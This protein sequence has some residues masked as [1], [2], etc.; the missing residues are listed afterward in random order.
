MS[1]FEQ[2][3]DT[4]PLSQLR[5][6][7]KIY[8]LGIAGTGM[9]TVAGLCKEAGF[10]VSGSDQAVY[11]PTAG[12][13]AAAGIP[14]YTP[15]HSDNLLKAK[16][17]LMVVGNA[18]SRGH[19]EL[20]YWISQGRP[21][22]SY[23]QVLGECFL[24]D[25]ASVVMTG[26]HG[27]TTTTALMAHVL[28]ELGEDP[29]W[30]IGGVP[31]NQEQSFRLGKSPLF[32][33]EGDEYNTAFFDKGAK[34]LHYRSRVL[35]LNN[36]EHDHVDIYPDFASVLAMFARLLTSC[37]ERGLIVANMDS[38]GVRQLLEANNAQHK[39]LGFAAGD[40]PQERRIIYG[41]SSYDATR[42][43]WVGT[44][45]TEQWGRLEVATQLPGQHN[46]SN[47]AGMLGCLARLKEGGHIKGSWGARELLASIASFPGVQK[48]FEE[49][50]AYNGC[51]V[52]LDF[53]HHPTAVG[54]VLEIFA[55]RYPAR[56]LIVAFD[57]KNVSS[58]RNIFFPLY[59]TAFRRAHVALIGACK[60]DVRIPLE[61]RMNIDALA[62]S[63]GPDAHAF[64]DNEELLKW[65][66]TH[67]QKEDVIIFLSCG[68]FS[69]IPRALIQ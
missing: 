51:P 60:E 44:I 39:V 12:M 19:P 49:I 31:Q 64:H 15:Y 20:E 37:E 59:A 13:L 21:M 62:R 65:V 28:T 33:L 6:G 67:A 23:P 58:R 25:K 36:L 63:I 41:P 30:F 50:G 42:D 35:L 38:P 3:L 66:R 9:A 4:L 34:F 14:V 10:D 18:I 57:P 55:K 26:T 1:A 68:D 56:R 5:P 46:L 7:A 61:E 52:Y 22:A 2:N 69:N 40:K 29:S 47:I 32:V 54:N 24:A 53:A 45:H 16:P 11:Q 43:C 8:F 17:D 27:K 48:R